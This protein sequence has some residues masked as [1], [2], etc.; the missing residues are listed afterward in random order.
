M[1]LALPALVLT[2]S[3]LSLS[4]QTTGRIAGRVLTKAGKPVAGAKITLKRLDITWTKDLQSSEDGQYQQVGLSP[5]EF[6]VLVSAP[7]YVDMQEVIKVPLGDTLRK[8]FTLLT[9]EEAL[10]ERKASGKTADVEIAGAANANAGLE[11]YNNATDLLNHQQ[12]EE[13]VPLLATAVEKLNLGLTE[14]KDETTKGSIQKNLEKVERTR[15]VALALAAQKSG[16]TEMAVQAEPLLL[17]AHTATPKDEN[18]L[19]ALVASYQAR[20][21]AANEKKYQDLLDA[22]VGP[23]PEQAYNKGVEAFNANRMA[24]AKTHLLKAVTI[25]PKYSNAY[26]LLAMVEF[27]SMNLKGTKGYLQK[28]LELDPNGAKA[29]KV[30]A[31]LADPSLKNIK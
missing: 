3:A 11:A 27:S 13:A 7:G 28:Y 24:E 21:D 12:F 5:K 26:Y 22:V 8:D 17:K 10:A 25:D 29:A 23:K 18:V 6:A 31:M 14:A 4:A 15:G 9:Q 2:L 1:R 30:K 20:K 19:Q 16:N